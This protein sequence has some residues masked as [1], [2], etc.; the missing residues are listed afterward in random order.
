MTLCVDISI[1]VDA[2]VPVDT[3]KPLSVLLNTNDPMN[4]G[5]TA[6]L[7]FALRGAVL[8]GIANVLVIL[9]FVA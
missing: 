3:H 4:N 8:T 1:H 5:V 7:K 2:V 6:T 9:P